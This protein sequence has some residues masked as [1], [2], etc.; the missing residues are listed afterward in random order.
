M[1]TRN[2]YRYRSRYRGHIFRLAS[3]RSCLC[4]EESNDH[5]IHDAP[6]GEIVVRTHDRYPQSA[7]API[8][9]RLSDFVVGRSIFDAPCSALAAGLPFIPP[10]PCNF[11]LPTSNFPTFNFARSARAPTSFPQPFPFTSISFPEPACSVL[12]TASE[13]RPK[14]RSLMNNVRSKVLPQNPPRT[15]RNWGAVR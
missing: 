9:R 4:S 5:A 14:P 6:G 7:I 11:R 12:S 2:R 3:S 1:A 13:N 15:I 8:R 10:P